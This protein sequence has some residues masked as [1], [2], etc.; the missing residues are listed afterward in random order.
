MNN[1][2]QIVKV[3]FHRPLP[4]G[5]T[6]FYFGSVSAIFDRFTEKEIGCGL[7]TLW[8]ATIEVGR[9]KITRYCTISRHFVYRK[10]Q[11]K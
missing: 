1:R 9:P 2:E 7:R 8:S 5:E 10:K 3:K 4:D 6:E 11:R